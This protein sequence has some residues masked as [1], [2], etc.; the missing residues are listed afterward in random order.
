MAHANDLWAMEHRTFVQGS[1]T[2]IQE[3]QEKIQ[4]DIAEAKR[5][6]DARLDALEARLR[7]QNRGMT[8]RI[9]RR[10]ARL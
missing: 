6:I 10:L 1:L 3:S 8:H 7:E 2:Q 9:M 5:E 4:E